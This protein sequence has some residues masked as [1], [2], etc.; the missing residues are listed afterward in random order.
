MSNIPNA[1]DVYHE[2]MKGVT[3]QETYE[4]QEKLVVQEMS[5]L[6]KENPTVTVLFKALPDEKLVLQL[7][8]RGYTVKYDTFYDSTKVEKYGTR[9]RITNPKFAPKGGTFMD[10]LEDQLKSCP[11]AQT[12]TGGGIQISGD[13]KK[14]MESFFG[15][16]Q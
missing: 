3:E 12:G 7:E 10:K 5:K 15:S 16:F 1:E 6:T 11:F 14:L 13:A 8:E 2:E 9:L 4:F